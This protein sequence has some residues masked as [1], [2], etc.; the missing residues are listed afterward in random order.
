MALELP[1]PDPETEKTK[2]VATKAT[3][4]E[5]QVLRAV[6]QGVAKYYMRF[7]I[8][9]GNQIDTPDPNFPETKLFST[10][11]IANDYVSDRWENLAG[12]LYASLGQEGT[13]P[14]VTK[15]RIDLVLGTMK[16]ADQANEDAILAF[17][18][19]LQDAKIKELPS[20]EIS[21]L[22]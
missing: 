2:V 16:A 18:G 8:A 22:E 7:S 12:K 19:L 9:Y 15:E 20:E 1:T 11:S 17:V 21:K 4:S 10:I 14:S 3:V 13:D 5:Y 6:D